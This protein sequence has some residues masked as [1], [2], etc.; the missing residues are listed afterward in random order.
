MLFAV[1]HSVDAAPGGLCALQELA[2]ILR[3]RRSPRFKI[4]APLQM[5]ISRCL[6]SQVAG[7]IRKPFHLSDLVQ[8]LGDVLTAK[9]EAGA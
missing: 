3:F 2:G 8:L 4:P 5:D 1:S 6:E 9:R 7:F